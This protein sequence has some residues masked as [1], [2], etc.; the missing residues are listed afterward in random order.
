MD[1]PRVLESDPQRRVEVVWESGAN[2][3]RAVNLEVVCV[4]EPGM[5]GAITKSIGAAG[6]NITRA[7]VQSTPEKQALNSFE[8]MVGTADQLNKVIRTIGKLK[9]VIR[10]S[11][12]RV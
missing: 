3:V 2:G 8:I 6:V 5:L 4:D 10:V 12:P 7:Q 11:R 1:C 9:G